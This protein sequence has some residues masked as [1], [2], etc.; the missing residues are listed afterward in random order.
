MPLLEALLRQQ[1]NSIILETIGSYHG[2]KGL[3]ENNFRPIEET[4][5]LLTRGGTIKKTY[6][7]KPFKGLGKEKKLKKNL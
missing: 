3:I 2:F 1:K 4:S 7:K 5:G 6:R